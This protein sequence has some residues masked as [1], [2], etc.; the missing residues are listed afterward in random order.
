MSVRA[1]QILAYAI[2]AISGIAVWAFTKTYLSQKFELG[3]GMTLLASL[4]GIVLSM[5]TICIVNISMAK[6]LRV[7]ELDL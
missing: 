5:V 6:I 1:R 2:A 4:A 7:E 3:D